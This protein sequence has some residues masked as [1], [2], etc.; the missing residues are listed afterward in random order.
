MNIAPSSGNKL[1]NLNL[2]FKMIL[3]GLRLFSDVWSQNA[4]LFERFIEINKIYKYYTMDLLLGLR[5]EIIIN[6]CIHCL[7]LKLD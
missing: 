3:R 5:R 1:L 4:A 7:G 6:L 2:P